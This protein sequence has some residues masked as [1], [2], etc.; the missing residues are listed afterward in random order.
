M[1]LENMMSKWPTHVEDG[2]LLYLEGPVSLAEGTLLG[3]ACFSGMLGSR[4]V[5]EQVI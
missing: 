5:L 3:A 4:V 2:L 1:E